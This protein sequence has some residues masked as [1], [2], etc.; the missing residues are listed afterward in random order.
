MRADGISP[1]KAPSVKKQLKMGMAVITEIRRLT[2]SKKSS[3]TKSLLR[4]V[5]LNR[6]R[7]ISQLSKE[8]GVCS[9]SERNRHEFGAFSEKPTTQH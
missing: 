2:P 9:V 6:N 1:R 7:N 5:E 8:L 3:V 4:G